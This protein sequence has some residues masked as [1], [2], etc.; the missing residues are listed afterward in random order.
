MQYDDIPS[1]YEQWHH[2]ITAECG[3]PLTS[4]FVAQRLAVWKDEDAQETARFRRLYGDAHWRT[5]IGWFEKAGA[6]L[7]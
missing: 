6:E 4:E 5:V 3:I 2:C 7:R 1:T